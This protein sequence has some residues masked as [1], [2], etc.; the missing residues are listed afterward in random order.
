M[1]EYGYPGGWLLEAKVN[2]AN[3]L[4]VHNG[5]EAKIDD[6][7]LADGNSKTNSVAKSYSNYEFIYFY[8]L[9][10]RLLQQKKKVRFKKNWKT[11]YFFAFQLNKKL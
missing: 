5:E 7:D 2:S 6:T 4:S 8:F 1:R 9:K 10:V 11:E 3:K